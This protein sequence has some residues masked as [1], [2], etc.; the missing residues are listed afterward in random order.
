VTFKPERIPLHTKG[1]PKTFLE[2]TTV[3]T[4]DAPGEHTLRAQVNDDQAMTRRRRSVLD[5]GPRKS[6]GH[7]WLA[8]RA[9]ASVTVLRLADRVLRDFADP[10]CGFA[11]RSTTSLT[12]LRLR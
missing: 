8:L 1:D 6:I 2:A 10:C 7:N 5:D 9:A 3:A 12:V 11:D 4:F